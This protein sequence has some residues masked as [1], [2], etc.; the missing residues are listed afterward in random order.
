MMS[1][2]EKRREQSLRRGTTFPLRGGNRY[3]TGELEAVTVASE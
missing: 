2:A 3:L 1:T